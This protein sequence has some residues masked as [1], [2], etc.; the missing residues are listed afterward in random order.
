M[1]ILD[2]IPYQGSISDI[3][4]TDIASIDILKDA[5]ASAIYGRNP[6]MEAEAH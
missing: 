6:L 3:N 2:G 1:I 5:S 4:P